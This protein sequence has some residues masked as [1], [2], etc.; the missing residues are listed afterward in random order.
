MFFHLGFQNLARLGVERAQAVLVHQHGL[1]AEPRLPRLLRDVLEDALAEF[2]GISRV[3]ESLGL[4]AEF[5]ALHHAGHRSL[6][7]R[8]E[9]YRTSRPWRNTD[10]FASAPARTSLSARSPAQ[11]HVKCLCENSV[12]PPVVA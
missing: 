2:A 4:F 9:R 12:S 11:R 6:P 8:K 10:G 1:V 5:D 7:Y 3:V